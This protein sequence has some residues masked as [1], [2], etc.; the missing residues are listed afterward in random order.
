MKQGD[1]GNLRVKG[2]STMRTTG[3]STTRPARSCSGPGSRP[4][5]TGRTPTAISGTP[6]VRRHAQGRRNLGFSGGGRSD[7]HQARRRAGSGGRG[8]GGRRS[9]VK[10]KAFVV[11]KE[12]HMP[13]RA[14]RRAEGVRRTRSRPFISLDR[15]R[16]RAAQDGHREDPAL[17]A[18]RLSVFEPALETLSRELRELQW[19]KLQGRWPRSCRPAA[20]TRSFAERA[21]AGSAAPAARGWE[22]RP[23]AAHAKAEFVADQVATPFGTNL[24]YPVERYVRVHQ[25]SGTSGKPIR[26]LD[27]QESWDWWIR[28]G[29]SC[30]GSRP[31]RRRPVFFPFSFGLFIGFWA[32]SRAPGARRAD[33]SGQDSPT[34]LAWMESL[35][36]TALCA[37]PPMRSTWWRSRASA[38]WTCAAGRA[39]DGSRRGARAF[40]PCGPDRSGLGRRRSITRA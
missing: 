5:R 9:A 2:D 16:G 1:I 32:G 6:A 23:A 3:T 11:L 15:V 25:T 27:T 37:P 26:W 17:Q 22:D 7:A 36:A 4:W 40:P 8:Q 21:A 24:T 19:R 34:R 12:P 14:G 20:A 31:H 28:C 30:S 13:R 38:E 29:A 39:H 18:A 35:G 33:D 10:P